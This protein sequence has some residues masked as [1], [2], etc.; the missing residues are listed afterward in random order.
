MLVC[1]LNLKVAVSNLSLI[2]LAIWN[3]SPRLKSEL[4]SR[5]YDSNKRD[6]TSVIVSPRLVPYTNL[7]T[8]IHVS[9]SVLVKSIGT[10]KQ[11]FFIIAMTLPKHHQLKMRNLSYHD[12]MLI[13]YHCDY[14]ILSLETTNK[15]WKMTTIASI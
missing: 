4:N 3:A 8:I 1:I 7:F 14:V 11:L 13:I 2:T 10:M 9:T 6:P 5:N 15:E 12:N